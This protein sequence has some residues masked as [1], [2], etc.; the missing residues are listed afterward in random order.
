MIN[1]YKEV[2]ECFYKDECYSV[3][4][5][6]AVMRHLRAGKK[7]RKDDGVWTF[8]VKS[9]RHGYMLLGQCLVRV[10]RCRGLLARREDERVVEGVPA[11]STGS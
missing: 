11:R 1:D 9:P 8:G 6:G 7:P 2:K 3:R 5:N 4:D 10:R